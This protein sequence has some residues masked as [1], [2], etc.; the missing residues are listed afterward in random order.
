MNKK[1]ILLIAS[2]FMAPKL[3]S[4][5]DNYGGT[6]SFINNFCQSY[7]SIADISVLATDDATNEYPEVNLIKV[8]SYSRAYLEETSGAKA[9]CNNGKTVYYIANNLNMDDY[10][11]IIDNTSNK[12]I[13]KALKAKV[14][15]NS[16]RIYSIFHGR[17]SYAGRNV[18]DSIV[19]NY[20]LFKGIVTFVSVTQSA[21]DEWNKMSKKLVGDN[22]VTLNFGLRTPAQTTIVQFDYDNPSF[23]T[24]GRIDSVKNFGQFNKFAYD[25]SNKGMMFTLY[26]LLLPCGEK[27]YLDLNPQ[28]I[29]KQP[30]LR[31]ELNRPVAEKTRFILDTKPMTVSTSI[32]ENGG[33]TC[34]ESMS[35]GLPILVVAHKENG[36]AKY[37]LDGEKKYISDEFIITSH[38]I[39]LTQCKDVIRNFNKAV[40]LAMKLKPF[41]SEK[42]KEYWLKNYTFNVEFLDSL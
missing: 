41:D 15:S 33:T 36:C 40:T 26:G 39:L 30:N 11:V 22:L 23:V 35:F 29:N 42:I 32:T 37:V 8:G 34:L 18:E 10:D 31:Y 13:L 28:K 38:G 5:C 3:G 4:C 21:V 7:R 1:R 19:E 16:P 27:S 12:V 24:V 9:R 20:N 6:E 2:T 25:P 17:P 14:S